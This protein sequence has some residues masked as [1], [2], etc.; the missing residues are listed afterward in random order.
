MDCEWEERG[1]QDGRG[2]RRAGY[3]HAGRRGHR[4]YVR[5]ENEYQLSPKQRIRSVT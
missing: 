5:I 2:A 1:W 4:V 3:D